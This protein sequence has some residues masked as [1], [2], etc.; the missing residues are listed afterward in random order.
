MTSQRSNRIPPDRAQGERR[1]PIVRWRFLWVAVVIVILAATAC[2]S[3][4]SALGR[5]YQGSTLHIKVVSI[6]RA[7]EVR[8]STI[9]P[10]GRWSVF[11]ETR[12]TELVL[13]RLEVAN[14]T[15]VSA[16]VHVDR[17]AAELRDFSGDSY[18]PVALS[19]SVYQDLRGESEVRV[20]MDEGQCFD[21]KRLVVETG[22]LVQWTNIGAVDH[23]VEF[24]GAEVPLQSTGQATLAPAGTVSHMFSQA[25]EFDYSC[26][27]ADSWPDPAKVLVVEKGSGADVRE[28]EWQFLE[29]P[30][31]LPKGY[32]V[33]GWMIFEVPEGTEFRDIR[34]RAGDSITVSF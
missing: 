3:T 27:S 31:E 10:E 17:A 24:Y 21:P 2:S 13:V 19:D 15:A 7:P 25:G 32:G 6:D 34:W 33:D 23:F 4:S 1:P 18:F 22:T 11:P 12:G 14:H 29:G 28:R 9:D 8:Y 5:W 26:R 30:F 16:I 20:H